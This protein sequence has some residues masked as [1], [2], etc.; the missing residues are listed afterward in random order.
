MRVLN[1][2]DWHQYGRD[3][4]LERK[5]ESESL[6]VQM[7]WLFRMSDSEF[8]TVWQGI[9]EYVLYVRGANFA[10]LSIKRITP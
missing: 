10:Q 9:L 1:Y 2:L 4:L 3:F 8:A 5:G 7:F 6:F